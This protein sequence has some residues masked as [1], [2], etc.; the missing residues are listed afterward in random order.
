[1]QHSLRWLGNAQNIGLGVSSAPGD[2][3]WWMLGAY[4]T[5]PQMIMGVAKNSKLGDCG[6]TGH[7]G[8]GDCGWPGNS[9]L[10]DGGR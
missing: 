6:G 1:M 2:L 10:D 7:S 3:H 8:F 4:E 9:I 5:V